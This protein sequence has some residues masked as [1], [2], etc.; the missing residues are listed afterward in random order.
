MPDIVFFLEWELHTFYPFTMAGT[1]ALQ[2]DHPGSK[3]ASTTYQ[4]WTLA[5]LFKYWILNFPSQKWIIMMI[6]LQKRW[7]AVHQKSMLFFHG[8]NLFNKY[9]H[10]PTTDSIFQSLLHPDAAKDKFLP[11]RYKYKWHVS[12]PGLGPWV[13]IKRKTIHWSGTPALGC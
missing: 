1:G 6:L 4:L 11:R 5:K 7:L 3:P 13:P 12:L 8:V 10:H 9:N 2:L